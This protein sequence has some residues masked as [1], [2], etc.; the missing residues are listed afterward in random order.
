MVLGRRRSRLAL[1]PSDPSADAPSDDGLPVVAQPADGADGGRLRGMSL[2][3][4]LGFVPRTAPAAL[5]AVL[6]APLDFW[7]AS[8]LAA[9]GPSAAQVGEHTL[10]VDRT[11][12]VLSLPGLAA[13]APDGTVLVTIGGTADVFAL[14]VLG[15]RPR[16]RV[17]LE[18]E[19]VQDEGDPLPVETILGGGGDGADID[20]E[21]AH[22][23]LFCALAGIEPAEL[24]ELVW[25]PLG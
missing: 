23:A 11:A 18:R 21:D 5:G 25:H 13:G 7:E 17:L 24:F 2:N 14:E 15:T 10:L 12:D 6:G 9:T 4:M 19:L 1:T 8:G 16:L 3:V 22:I 20:P